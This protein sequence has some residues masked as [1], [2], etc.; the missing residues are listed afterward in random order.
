VGIGQELRHVPP[1]YGHQLYLPK[2]MWASRTKWPLIL[3]LHGKSLRGSD[4]KRVGSYGLP[5]RLKTDKGFPFI[6]IAPQ[7]P[8]NQRWTDT[9]ALASLVND[10]ASMYPV[11][12]T[13]V[14]AMGFS[15]GAS[16]TWRV[17]HDYPSMFAAVVSVAGTYEKPLATSGRL[18]TVPIWVIH[19]TADKDASPEV[20]RWVL[21][22]H[23]KKGGIGHFTGMAGKGHNIPDVF[24]KSGIYKWVLGFRNTRRWPAKL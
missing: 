2:K 4:L 11:D 19:G 20:A 24:E 5:K 15:M 10:V 13:R 23:V 7:L 12:R 14:Y 9:R 21:D 1:R 17:A 3:F 16:G 22:M 18:K 8:A 6:V